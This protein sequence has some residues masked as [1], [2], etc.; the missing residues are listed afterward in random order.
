MESR[1]GEPAEVR[2]PLLRHLDEWERMARRAFLR[3]YRKAMSGQPSCPASATEAEALMVL[4]MAE[5]AVSRIDSALVR[6]SSAVGSA[7]WRLIQLA[8]RG[9]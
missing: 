3:S 8:E 6:H 5:L 7:M 2:A 9:R 1:A 4:A